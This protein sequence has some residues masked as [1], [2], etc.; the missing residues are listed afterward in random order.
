[1]TD[2]EDK[3][4]QLQMVLDQ[5]KEEGENVEEFDHDDPRLED[6]GEEGDMTEGDEGELP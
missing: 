6:Q 5:L 4:D 1:M 2:N 3:N